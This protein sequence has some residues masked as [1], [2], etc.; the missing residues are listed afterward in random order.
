MDQIPRITEQ[1]LLNTLNTLPQGIIVDDTLRVVALSIAII[2]HFLGVEWFDQHMTP[3][4]TGK[5]GFLRI[6]A[7][8]HAE[9]QTSAFRAVDFAE[10]IFNLQNIEGFDNCLQ[11]MKTASIEATYA[12]IDFGRWLYANQINFRFI[13]PIGKKRYDYDVEII[14]EDGVQVCADAKCKIEE[15]EF[16]HESVINTLNSA[17][18]QFPSDRPSTI[19]VKVPSH[20]FADLEHAIALEGIARDFLRGT[21]RVVSI[22][23]YSNHLL[24]RD[25]SLSHSHAFKEVTNPRNRFDQ[26]RDWEMFK[27]RPAGGWNG[28][29]T[30]YR[31]LVFFPKRGPDDQK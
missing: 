24:Y 17:R 6:I 27:T 19:F 25:G 2:K 30:V 18:K 23:F 1:H 13:K 21:Q 12:E 11:Q 5:S 29:P 22:I 9:A 4:E 3:T 7:G 31:R 16:S 28:M 10:A 15:N 20:W 26:E 14:F 8:S